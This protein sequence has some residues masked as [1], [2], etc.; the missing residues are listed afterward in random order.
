MAEGVSDDPRGPAEGGSPPS[1]TSD[2]KLHEGRDRLS[3]RR[4]WC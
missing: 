2:A 4:A 1:A 3:G